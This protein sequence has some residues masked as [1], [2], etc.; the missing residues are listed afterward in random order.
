MATKKKKSE[1]DTWFEAQHGKPPSKH[2]EPELVTKLRS[3]YQTVQLLETTL[4]DLKEYN[5]RYTSA[6]WA[7]NAQIMKQE[8]NTVKES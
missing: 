4:K 1:F 2:S 3:A 7:W 5:A 8:E 6:R